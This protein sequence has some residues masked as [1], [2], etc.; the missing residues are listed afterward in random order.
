MTDMADGVNFQVF[1]NQPRSRVSWTSGDWRNGW[2]ALDRNGN[3]RID[4]FSELFGDMTLQPRGSDRNG[5]R[6]L[7][8]F[9]DP[10]NGGNGNGFI[11]PGDKCV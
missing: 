7:A 9:D 10:S 4:D 3:G 6:A 2:L 11:D 5:Y 8:V 1:V